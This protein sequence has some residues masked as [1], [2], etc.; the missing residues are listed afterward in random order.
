MV[1]Y[2]KPDYGKEELKAVERVLDSGWT[3]QGEQVALFEKEF[4]ISNGSRYAIAV[5]NATTGL[6][7]ACTLMPNAEIIIPNYNFI[8]GYQAAK[9]AK[10]KVLISTCGDDY[11]IQD[12]GYI[13]PG[14]AVMPMHFGGSRCDIKPFIDK[15]MFII[16]DC[17]HC[18]PANTRYKGDIQVYSFYANKCI[19]IG[20][21]GMICTDNEEFAY[22]LKKIKNHGRS[23]NTGYDYELTEEGFNFKMTDIQ[24]SIGRIQLARANYNKWRRHE[25]ANRY[26]KN[27]NGVCG[28]ANSDDDNN[29][30]HLV[31]IRHER[32]E[33]IRDEF[34][35]KDI[36][37]SRHYKPINQNIK[38]DMDKYEQSV[39]LP[40]YP[41]MR[42]E[43]VDEV[44]D[45][46]KNILKE[47]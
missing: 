34:V 22:K 7:L 2:Y 45:V 3:T 15:K 19:S 38:R 42:L 36:R 27:L 33:E 13:K 20:E 47:G 30:W 29:D 5:S 16:E 32:A 21:G 14:T 10:K 1:I 23:I 35:N 26:K 28:I 46:I 31:V 40:I 11:K 43:D 24:A 39:S 41:E 18:I 44:C 9:L 25:V 8:A 4:A 37:F 17:A 6:Y 12:T